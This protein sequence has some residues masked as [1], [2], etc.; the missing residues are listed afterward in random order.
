[1]VISFEFAVPALKPICIYIILASII[2]ISCAQ[3][4]TVSHGAPADSFVNTQGE[5]IEKLYL[6]KREWAERLTD[7]GYFVL[8]Q[9][10]T[11]RAFTGK[12]WNYHEAGIFQCAGC[13]LPLFSS[14]T[15][16]ESGTGW[17]SFYQPVDNTHVGES[18]DVLFGIPRTEVHCNRCGGHLGHVFRDGPAPTGLRYCINSVSLEFDRDPG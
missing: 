2:P 6:T 4:D 14:K 11:E 3:Q 17:P 7:Q 13:G 9:S 10:G 16:F 15:K 5:I 1:M 12:Y 18:R 8:R